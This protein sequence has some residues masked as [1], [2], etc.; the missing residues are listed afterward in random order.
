[1]AQ[2]DKSV[3]EF[4]DTTMDIYGF[5]PLT[6]LKRRELKFKL[7]LADIK[8]TVKSDDIPLALDLVLEEM[9]YK[10]GSVRTAS[11]RGAAKQP[12]PRCSS[13]MCGVKINASTEA[14]YCTACHVT[15]PVR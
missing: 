8:D 7:A 6:N 1:M 15:I 10:Q 5:S 2:K 12:C 14:M 13:M 11:F 3:N 4:L 9:E